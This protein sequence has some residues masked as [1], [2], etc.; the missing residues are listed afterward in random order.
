MHYIK[1]VL[2]HIIYYCYSATNVLLQDYYY[3]RDSDI[4][5]GIH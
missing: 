2:K 1:C 5:F 3:L 4:Q